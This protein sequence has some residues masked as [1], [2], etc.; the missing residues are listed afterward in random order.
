VRG[1]LAGPHDGD[2]ALLEVAD[3]GPGIPPDL[4]EAVFERFRQLDGG[5]ARRFGGTG[6]GLSIARDLVALHG[7]TLEVGQAPEG[8]ALF[9]VK[10]PLAVRADAAARAD[11]RQEALADVATALVDELGV[12]RDLVAV[13]AAAPAGAP[14]VLVIEDNPELCAFIRSGLAAD[15]RTKAAADG[16]VGFEQALR[17]KPDLVL[18]DVMMPRMGGDTLVKA[19][20]R[21]PTFAGTP[22]LVIT[23]KADDARLELL[24]LGANDC[25][26]KPFTL[27]ELR[28]RAGN[29]LRAKLTADANARLTDELRDKVA[30]LY[31]LASQLETSNRELES[32]SYSVSHDLRAP[33]R[34]IQGFSE[35]ILRE[36]GESLR[37]QPAASSSASS[38]R[39]RGCPR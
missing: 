10:L 32:F 8:G 20:R 37:P 21:E 5:S 18:T 35:V 29:L 12:S 36:H 16:A 3:S 30:R 11:V 31:R 38:P 24:R 4:R 1:S 13:P 27:D 22:I 19:L 2:Q 26:T 25:L 23:A 34:A 28:A 9:Q 7:G 15:Y 17:L 33:L 6:L 14:L 39:P